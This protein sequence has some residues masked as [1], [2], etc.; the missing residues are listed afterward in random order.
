[1]CSGE[2]RLLTQAMPLTVGVT[3]GKLL[4]LSASVSS[5]VKE[6]FVKN[7]FLLFH[8]IVVTIK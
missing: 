7:N 6:D 3:S 8:K 4:K 2:H 5:S 1:M